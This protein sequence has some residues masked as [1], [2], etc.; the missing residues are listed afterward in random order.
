MTLEQL[1]AIM[2]HKR[3]SYAQIR[4]RVRLR[5]EA[6]KNGKEYLNPSYYD[7]DGLSNGVTTGYDTELYLSM[8][9]SILEILEDDTLE[10]SKIHKIVM[11]VIPWNQEVILRPLL[12]NKNIWPY[13]PDEL[14]RMLQDMASRILG[15]NPRKP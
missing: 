5:R 14:K 3:L 2:E 8:L 13:F 15:D 9:A 12:A 7:E 4:R 1:R 6:R 11:E 10:E